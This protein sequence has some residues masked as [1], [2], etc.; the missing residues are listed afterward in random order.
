[1]K[2]N[3]NWGMIAV[4]K[5]DFQYQASPFRLTVDDLSVSAGE[6][7]V[8]IGPSGSGK[9]TLLNLLAGILLPDHGEISVAG[10]QLTLMSDRDRRN[11]RASNIGMV[12]QQFELLEYLT[13]IENVRLPFRIN[14]ST[15]DT[16]DKN[17]PHQLLDSVG[18]S[19]FSN[20]YPGQLS[21]GEQQR[22]AICR[23]LVTNPKMI[24]ADEPTGNLDPANKR[25][26]MDLLFR[27]TDS[28]NQTLVVVT[29][30]QSLLEDFDRVIDFETFL[31]PDA[32]DSNSGAFT[33]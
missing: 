5:I 3:Y 27:E 6:K 22:V 20:R 13:V 8:I 15:I 1:V 14:L 30:D 11:F 25:K 17:T 28:R 12:F 23:A 32:G 9:T 29:H 31:Q 2:I 19:G 16:P 4:R 33:T 24:L 10:A 18:L 26:M 7:L 21:R